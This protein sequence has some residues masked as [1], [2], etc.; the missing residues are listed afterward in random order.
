MS[1][2]SGDI[3]RSGWLRGGF[4]TGVAA[5]MAMSTA[6]SAIA[7]EL[8]DWDYDP[9]TRSLTLVLPEATM[10]SVSV[11]APTQLSIELPDTQLGAV[12]ELTVDDGL[13]ESIVLEQV[14]PD[15][16]RMV[17]E[18][19]PGTVLADAQSATLVATADALSPGSQQWQVRPALLASSQSSE[20]A[21][22]ELQGGSAVALRP[23]DQ[24]AQMPDAELPVLAPAMPTD[25]FVSVPPLDTAPLPPAP[26]APL[27]AAPPPPPPVEA[28][29][30]P[31]EPVPVE[32]AP[33]IA[34]SGESAIAPAPA[35]P[36]EPPF[37]GEV[38]MSEPPA[39]FSTDLPV[40]PV[41]DSLSAEDLPEA[42]DETAVDAIE[43]DEIAQPEAPA[44]IAEATG[45]V[46]VAPAI[47]ED[48]A[49]AEPPVEF[50]DTVPTVD[51]S[52][53]TVSPANISRWPEPI[54]FGQPLP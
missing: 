25:E 8:T 37:I 4:A 43:A 6:I 36:T 32:A 48:E 12:S 17:V 15:T 46:P 27:P 20:A 42:Q 26:I 31:V 45:P 3:L 34:D 33:P 16:V 1:R 7:D 5:V 54:P 35:L 52:A 30:T 28:A 23:S 22:G 51:A 2:K 24:L 49:I 21:S 50:S 19:S 44:E 13:V 18:F 47:A 40:A 41:V 39:D 14:G 29:Q 53:D 38:G 11:V 10:P 9:Q